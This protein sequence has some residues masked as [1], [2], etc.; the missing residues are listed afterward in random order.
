MESWLFW[1]LLT[2]VAVSS[3]ALVFITS[4]AEGAWWA[5][6]IEEVV[7]FESKLDQT[8]AKSASLLAKAGLIRKLLEE[9]PVAV[10]WTLL[11]LDMVLYLGALFLGMIG[12]SNLNLGVVIL[13][14]F[15]P[16]VRFI[17]GEIVSKN[18]GYNKRL[19]VCLFSVH[20]LYFFWKVLGP[21]TW[22]LRQLNHWT[23]GQRR[24]I[25]EEDIVAAAQAAKEHGTL[26]QVEV[27][28]IVA[29][30][31]V[32][33][34]TA[35]ELMTPLANCR[36]ILSSTT[37]R[38]FRDAIKDEENKPIIVLN[39]K[40]PKEVFGVLSDDDAL[41]IITR[42]TGD[43]LD[44]AIAQVGTMRIKKEAKISFILKDLSKNPVGL[45]EDRKGR[46]IGVITLRELVSRF[47]KAKELD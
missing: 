21:I 5:L 45:V 16:T 2:T 12:E 18:M 43:K 46:V 29:F 9:R 4:L 8:S 37:L 33:N 22:L 6:R 25:Q 40:N 36:K 44:L 39:S 24:V 30:L 10:G 31:E 19:R 3:I 17:L 27:D 32:G 34:K 13:L 11:L 20:Y 1:L 26:D 41:N 28:V 23:G 42:Q 14:A 7:A 15:Y 47:T 38:L 35:G